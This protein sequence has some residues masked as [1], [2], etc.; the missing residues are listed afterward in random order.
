MTGGHIFHGDILPDQSFSLR[1]L[2]G[3][4]DYRTPIRSL[5]LCGSGTHPGGCVFGAPGY[6]AANEIIKDWKEGSIE[7]QSDPKLCLMSMGKPI[8]IPNAYP[9]LIA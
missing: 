4:S 8:S 9:L 1:Y 7:R 5:Y 6:N 3:W 2:S